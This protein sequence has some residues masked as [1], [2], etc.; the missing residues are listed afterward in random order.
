M[1]LKKLRSKKTEKSDEDNLKS[2]QSQPISN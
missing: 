2:N 1:E